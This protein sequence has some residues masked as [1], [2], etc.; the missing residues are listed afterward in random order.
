M[1]RAMLLFSAV[2]LAATLAGCGSKAPTDPTAATAPH[3]HRAEHASNP[4]HPI[5][6]PRPATQSAHAAALDGDDDDE[7]HASRT[8]VSSARSVAR[9]FFTTYL[10]YLYGQLPARDVTGLNQA[11]RRQLEHGHAIT[12]PAERASSPHVVRLSLS[13]S[14]PPISVTAIALLTTADSQPSQLTATLEPHHGTWLVV[15]ISG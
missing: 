6:R 12:T 3:P 2:A 14:G 9:A 7:P 11:L 15:A 1:V 10:A 4:R 8:Q 5:S 13:S